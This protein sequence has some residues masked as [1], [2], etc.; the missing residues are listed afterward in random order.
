MNE[1]L[2]ASVGRLLDLEAIR[3]LARAYAHCIWRRDADG[4]AALFTESGVMDT[5]DRPALVGRVAIR[6]AYRAI[7]PAAEFLP[8]VHD[9]RITLDGDHASGSCHLDL[10]ATQAG[11]SL[12]GAGVY[13][14]RYVRESGVWKFEARR[15]TLRFLVPLDEGWAG[16]GEAER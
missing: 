1:D 8:F 14:D 9:H 2:A 6:D 5:G 13:D 12:I 15:L 16:R 11:A 4:A 3:D 10:R 7:L